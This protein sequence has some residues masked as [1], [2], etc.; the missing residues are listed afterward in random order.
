MNNPIKLAAQLRAALTAIAKESH[1]PVISADFVTHP[2]IVCLNASDQRVY[3]AV[4]EMCR[5]GH[6][7]KIRVCRK[8]SPMA[9]WGYEHSESPVGPKP[10]IRP[11][12][13]PVIVLPPEVKLTVVKSS[14]KLRLEF[15]GIHIEIGVTE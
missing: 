13:E 9:K 2:A 15:R 1:E 12:K 14:G 7:R 11:P 3:A 10:A 6:L 8:D 5:K 4:S